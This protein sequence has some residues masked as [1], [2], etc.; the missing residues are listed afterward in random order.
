MRVGSLCTGYGGLDLAVEDLFPDAELAWTSEIDPSASRV[1]EARFPHTPNI[2]DLRRADPPPVDILH[3]GFPCQPV[4]LAGAR[5]GV[6]D[7]RWLWDDILALV[8]RMDPPPGLLLFENVLGLLSANGGD[9][10]ARVV[11]GLAAAGFVGRYRVLAASD[12]GACHRRSRVFIAAAHA[13]RQ[14][15]PGWRTGEDHEPRRA[16]TG[17]VPPTRTLIPTPTASDGA[18]QP[19]RNPQAILGS[20]RGGHAGRLQDAVALLPATDWGEYAEAITAHELLVGRPAPDPVA[21]GRLSA[22]FVEWMMCLP[23][24]WVTDVGLSNTATLRVLGNGVVPVQA[25]T[26]YRLLGVTE[27]AT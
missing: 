12:V 18:T 6:D 9:A 2:G 23:D 27:T 3:A 14:R 8:R 26:A 25:A 5:N 7:E 1:L 24:G 17:R 21:A 22:R 20:K 19:L 10:M 4:S 11:E 13:D 15:L 16:G